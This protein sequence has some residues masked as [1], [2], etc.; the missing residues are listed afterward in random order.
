MLPANRQQV[1]GLDADLEVLDARDVDTGD[2][3]DIVG[4]FEQREHDVVEVRRHVDHDVVEHRAQHA[5]HA[6]HLF[7]GDALAGRRLDGRAQHAQCRRFV[8][9]EE[10]VHQLRVDRVDHRRPRRRG[11]LRRDS[12]EHCDVTELKVG[13]DEHDPARIARR[14]Q[15]GEVR[16][17]DALADATLGGEGTK[18]DPAGR[19]ARPRRHG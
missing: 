14:E 5:H 2:Q 1:E 13:V 11:V 6:D 7:G 15:H 18:I 8:R 10:T 19:F 12:E 17:D 4:L 16:R 9:R 3:E